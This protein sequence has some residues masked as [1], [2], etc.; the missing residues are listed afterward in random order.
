MTHR[1]WAAAVAAAVLVPA[2]AACSSG[3]GEAQDATSSSGG[4]TSARTQQV[5]LD[6][7]VGDCLADLGSEDGAAHGAHG[8]AEPT[9]DRGTVSTAATSGATSTSAPASSSASASA[10]AS[11]AAST[12]AE[13]SAT[14]S[15]SGSASGTAS[16]TATSATVPTKA[17]EIS[18]V[19]CA[20]QHVG[21]VYAQQTLDDVLFPGRSQTKDRAADWCTGDEFTDFVGTGFGGSSLDV[22]TY[23]PSKESWAAKDRTVSCVVTDPAGPTTGSLAHAYR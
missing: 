20:G 6:L 18:T 9:D 17:S 15:A 3:D 23:V 22:V 8:A 14:D 7:S 19:D 10:S 16:G 4:S 21:E 2:L 12:S 5:G 13:P 11:A 1:L